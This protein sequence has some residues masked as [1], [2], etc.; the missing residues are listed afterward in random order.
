MNEDKIKERIMEANNV[1]KL[2]A[3]FFERLSKTSSDLDADLLNIEK[4]LR[5]GIN[6]ECNR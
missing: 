3:N 1:C 5:R 2:L 4:C 6:N